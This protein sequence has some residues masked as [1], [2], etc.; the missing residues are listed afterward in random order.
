[1]RSTRIQL[2]DGSDTAAI[3][4]EGGS[5]LRILCTRARLAIPHFQ[6]NRTRIIPMLGVRSNRKSDSANVT[7]ARYHLI[8]AV[9]EAAAGKITHWP[10]MGEKKKKTPNP[11]D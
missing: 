6:T 11:E 3:S 9:T 5:R 2:D 7:R 8:M 4:I 10:L 1:V